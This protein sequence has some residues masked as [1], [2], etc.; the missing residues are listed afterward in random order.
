MTQT[1]YEQPKE[2]EEGTIHDHFTVRLEQLSYRAIAV[3]EKNG[4]PIG[5]LRCLSEE[6]AQWLKERITGT[7]T[8]IRSKND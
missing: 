7:R 6:E 3:I 5:G 2:D 8:W 4:E 1:G